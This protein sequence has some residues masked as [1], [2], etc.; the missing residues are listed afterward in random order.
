MAFQWLACSFPTKYFYLLI[1]HICCKENAEGI[2]ETKWDF[3]N[4]NKDYKFDVNIT[5]ESTSKVFKY[6]VRKEQQILIHSDC[7]GFV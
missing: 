2:V 1:Y 4:L 6:K 3:W 5:V 7:V